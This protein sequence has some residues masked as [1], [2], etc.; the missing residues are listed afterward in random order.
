MDTQVNN[1]GWQL[2]KT[3]NAGHLV[4]VLLVAVSVFAWVNK[5]DGRVEKNKQ[6]IVFVKQEQTR[7]SKEVLATEAKVESIRIEIKSDLKDINSK[8]DRLI[9]KHPLGYQVGHKG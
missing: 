4:S 5:V 3:I 6:E 7:L 8:L 9:E 1:R 2:D